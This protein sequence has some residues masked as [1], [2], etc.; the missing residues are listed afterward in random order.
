M[1][2]PSTGPE[3]TMT[4]DAVRAESGPKQLPKGLVLGKD[5]KP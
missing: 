1:A 5:G 2:D 3:R 4:S